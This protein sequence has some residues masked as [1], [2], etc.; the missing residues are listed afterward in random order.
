[1][2]HDVVTFSKALLKAL[3]PLAM[4]LTLMSIASRDLVRNGNYG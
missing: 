2:R 4:S 1:M 3:T